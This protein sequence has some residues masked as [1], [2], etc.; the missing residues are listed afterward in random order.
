MPFKMNHFTREHL[1]YETFHFDTFLNDQAFCP[2][3][4]N[5]SDRGIYV[6]ALKNTDCSRI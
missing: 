4:K 3:Q 5:Q 2:A 1:R 6:E